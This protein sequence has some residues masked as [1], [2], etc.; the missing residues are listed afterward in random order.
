[1]SQ[2]DL[3]S[4]LTLFALLIVAGGLAVAVTQRHGRGVSIEVRLFLIAF[5]LRFAVSLGIYAFGLVDIVGDED[6]QEWIN[7]LN[8][9]RYWELYRVGLLDLPVV[10]AEAYTTVNRGYM[11]A[12]ALLYYL[13]DFMDPGRLVAAVFNGFCGALT[14]VIVYRA[15]YELFGARVARI[16][17][18]LACLFPS[19]IVWSAQTI[20]EPVVILLECVLI[21]CCVR[22]LSDEGGS[23][24]KH[25]AISTLAIALIIPFR[26]YGGYLG[27]AIV[28]FSVILRATVAAS[29]RLGAIARFGGVVVGVVVMTVLALNVAQ[30]QEYF[31]VDYLTKVKWYSATA[32]GSGVTLPFDLGSAEGVAFASVIGAV[33]LL[34]AP[35]PWQWTQGSTRLAFTIPEVVVWWVLFAVGVWPGIRRAFRERFVAIQ[36]V[37][38]FLVSFGLV[39]S[40]LFGNV[41][42][43]YRQRA[44]LLPWLLIFAAVGLEERF[45]RARR[46]R[47]A[48]APAFAA[49]GEMART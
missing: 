21:Y 47:R 44:Q 9:K 32:T 2:P 34:F 41:G 26:F 38:L 28:I 14:V 43:A 16:A 24:A 20:K 31:D 49:E 39:Y 17:G 1:M 19:L 45:A 46:G 29:A 35:L 3:I 25:L 37:I 10:L 40:V 23:L 22:L 48:P 8:V 42:L 27:A 36:P 18:W 4:S 12:L 6:A 7:G 33:H 30:D 13:W 11:F 5:V 15:G